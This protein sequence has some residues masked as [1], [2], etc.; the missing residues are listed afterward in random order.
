M[1]A[2]EEA[3]RRRDQTLGRSLVV[4]QVGDVCLK[5]HLDMQFIIKKTTSSLAVSLKMAVTA[6]REQQKVVEWL[7]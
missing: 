6:P 7:L 5:K 2:Q 4:L 1:L 3:R